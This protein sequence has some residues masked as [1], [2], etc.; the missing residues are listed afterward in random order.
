MSDQRVRAGDPDMGDLRCECVH[1]VLQLRELSAASPTSEDE[2]AARLKQVR[3][4]TAPCM[5]AGGGRLEEW[6]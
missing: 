6:A 3:S 5:Q 1:H 2:A 4:L